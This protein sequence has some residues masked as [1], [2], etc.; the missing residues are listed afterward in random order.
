MLNFHPISLYNVLYKIAFKA[1]VNS[2]QEVLR[3]CINEVQSA[4]VPGHL[5]FDNIIAAYEILNSM[6]NRR[7]GK[8]GSIAHKL[9]MSKAYNHVK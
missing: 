3:F 6:K 9:D 2:F 1:L 8:E 5:I 7:V 4:F